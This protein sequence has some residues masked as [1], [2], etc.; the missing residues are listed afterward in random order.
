MRQPRSAAGI[1]SRHKLRLR[2][3]K[4]GRVHELESIQNAM[5]IMGSKQLH[6]SGLHV[7]R[8]VGKGVDESDEGEECGACHE[9]DNSCI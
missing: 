1:S 8:S 2:E 7:L 3:K 5:H 9:T 6:G 4:G